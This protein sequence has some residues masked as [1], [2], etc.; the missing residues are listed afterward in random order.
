MPRL[1]SGTL[2]A[3]RR[4]VR[5]A[6]IATTTALVAEHGLRAVTMSRI[7]EQ[8]GIGRATLYKYFPD[9]ESILEAWHASHVRTHLDVLTEL[10]GHDSPAVQRLATV[11][12]TYALGI[13]ETSRQ[14]A[15]TDLVAMI[16]RS[17]HVAEAEHELTH[18]VARL[19]ADAAHEGTVRADVAPA[20]LAAFCLNALT[21]ARTAHSKAAVQRLVKL[22][23]SSLT[24]APS[25]VAAT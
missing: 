25:R 2:E 6:V 3:H 24:G 19:I 17:E 18:L 11:L 13:Y 20:E 23:L 1:W 14:H 8:S 9:V 12:R 7:A 16:H 4:E 5:D 22:A 10:A 15:S 21:A